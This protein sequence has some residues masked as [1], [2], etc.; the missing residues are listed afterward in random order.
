[1]TKHSLSA[2]VAASLVSY[3]L[4][5]TSAI[6]ANLGVGGSCCA[7]LEERVAELEATTAGK[8]NRKVRLLQ[9]GAASAPRARRADRSGS[10]M[11][12]A[13]AAFIVFVAA[14]AAG[15]AHA[16]NYDGSGQLRFGAFVQGADL[17]FDVQRPAVAAGTGSADGFG[18]GVSFGYDWVLRDRLVFGL[19]ADASVDDSSV[20]IHRRSFA[21]DYLVTL[22]GRLGAYLQPGWLVY[23]TGGAALLGVE[24]QRPF[25]APVPPATFG[26]SAT[27]ISDTLTGWTVGGGTELDLAGITLFTE[28]LYASFDTWEFKDSVSRILTQHEVDVDEHLVRVGV[29][30][31]IGHDFYDDDV[32]K[33]LK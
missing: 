3:G 32:R 12:V 17:E 8:G 20:K 4:P 26:D 1:M 31:K 23:A 14:A 28:Y 5:A 24:F 22:R 33:R 15:Q 18:G 19:E 6:A 2:V 21:S 27:K 13:S 10:F 29:K 7:D 30:F 16:Q 25:F 11:A 9:Y